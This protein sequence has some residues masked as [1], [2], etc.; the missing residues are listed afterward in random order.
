M[1]DRFDNDRDRKFG[2]SRSDERS[3]GR[4]QDE[5]RFGIGRGRSLESSGYRGGRD[6]ERSDWAR[7]RDERGWQAAP[8]EPRYSSD[9]DETYG[10]EW[11][12]GRNFDP[13][14]NERFERARSY[15]QSERDSG[16]YRQGNP[17][18]GLYG[19]GSAQGGSYGTG[20][21]GGYG[22][23]RGPA[24]ASWSERS[25]GESRG[26]GGGREHGYRG[27]DLGARPLGAAG[28]GFAGR[29]PKGYS[30]SDDRIRE[31]VCD[32]LSVDDD[33]DASEIEVKVQGAEVTLEGSVPTRAMKHQA[34][35][36]ADEVLGVKDV[37]NKLRVDKGLLTEIK[38][39]LTGSDAD[40][41]YANTGTKNAPAPATSGATNGRL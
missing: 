8:S 20:Y 33:V 17:G 18:A 23:G 10:S 6:D 25:S 16:W 40:R 22:Y 5:G 12:R 1:N 9:E 14:A 13:R 4:G 39:K 24:G 19:G 37:H 26:F 7:G 29:G 41:H 3:S 38:D 36:L 28:G 11:Q 32:R 21:A 2:E 35:N 31:D 30:R 27:R 34:E 15:A